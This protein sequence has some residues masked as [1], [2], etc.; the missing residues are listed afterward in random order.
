[1]DAPHIMNRR[2]F[3]ES[4]L[5]NFPVRKRELLRR[6]GG[7]TKKPHAGRVYLRRFSH[8]IDAPLRDICAASRELAGT[9]HRT[10]AGDMPI[11]I[12][13]GR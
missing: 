3:T 7:D 4:E 13:G 10:W 2:Y 8:L 11:A 1:M 12:S 9:S 5:G 6:R